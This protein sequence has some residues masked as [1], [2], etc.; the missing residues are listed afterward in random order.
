MRKH[1]RSF[2]QSPE[3]DIAATAWRKARCGRQG[4][5]PLPHLPCIVHFL[6]NSAWC[7][8]LVCEFR[9]NDLIW[10]HTFSCRA[11]LV[12]AV[13]NVVLS[14][15]VSWVSHCGADCLCGYGGAQLGN[16][17]CGIEASHI[18]TRSQAKDAGRTGRERIAPEV[19][20]KG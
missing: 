8:F 17:R 20:W 19:W 4:F 13:G 15:C 1:M 14:G 7:P 9:A 16:T 2:T 12:L 6:P 11:S 10:H 3:V 18:V 5:H